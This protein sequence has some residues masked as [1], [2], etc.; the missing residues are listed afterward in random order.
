VLGGLAV[1]VLLALPLGILGA[2]HVGGLLD[3][4]LTIAALVGAS[5]PP[6]L[7]S[8]FLLHWLSTRLPVATGSGYCPLLGTATSS[9]SPGAPAITCGGAVDWARHLLLPWLAFGLGLVALYSRMV[10]SGV[11]DLLGEPHVLVARAKGASDSQVLRRH[12]LRNALPPLLT[13]LSMDIGMALGTAVYVEIV[14]GLQGLGL[15][16]YGAVVAQWVGF[17]LPVIAGVVLIAAVVIVVLN[18]VVDLLC[19]TL[20]PRIRLSGTSPRG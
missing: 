12:V 16:A 10:R 18:L 3:R 6:F 1:V 11:L 13:M 14:F 4:G 8:Y 20:D 7:I 19:A 9:P 17:D 15:Q 2:L 5:V